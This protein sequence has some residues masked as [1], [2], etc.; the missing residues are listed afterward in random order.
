[1]GTPEVFVDL[2]S[3]E[4][5]PDGAVVDA[6]G[7]LWNAQWGAGRVACYAPDGRFVQSVPVPASQATCPAFNGTMLYVTTAAHGV[8]DPKAGLTYV[9]DIGIAGQTEHRVIL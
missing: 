5:N 4:L 3:E 8:N 2:R 9:T 6:S 7:N 1:M